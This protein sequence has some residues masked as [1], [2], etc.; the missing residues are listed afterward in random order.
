MIGAADYELIA[1]EVFREGFPGYRPNVVDVPGGDGKA[2][3]LKKLAHINVNTLGATRRIPYLRWVLEHLHH[4]ALTVA[5]RMGLPRAFYP[6][7]ETSALRVLYYPA[8]V[9]GHLHK[10]F[11]LFTLLVWRDTD[12]LKSGGYAP[13]GVHIGEIT[14]LLGCG[15]ATPHWVNPGKTE[16]RS[17]VYAALPDFSLTLPNGQTVK[18]WWNARRLRSQVKV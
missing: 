9:G 16:Q 1:G 12:D 8:G 13:K 5:R 2:D 3:H 4:E 6:V 10:D 7:A 14:E 11:D 18:E 17:L 15:R